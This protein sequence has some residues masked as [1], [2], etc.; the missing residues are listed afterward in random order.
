MP[1]LATSATPRRGGRAHPR[2]GLKQVDPLQVINPH[3]AGIDI[4]AA[5]HY[6]AVPA[7]ADPQSGEN[8]RIFQS[9]TCDLEAIVA[10]LKHCQVTTVAMESTGVYWIP[11]FDLL[12]REGLRPMLVDARRTK[13]L[14]C[15][16]SDVSDCQWI[17]QLHSY[18]LLQPA[19]RP[20]AEIVTL[21]CLVRQRTRLIESAAMCVQHM[22][23]ALNLMNLQLQ[24]VISDITGVTGM[25][26]M[27]AIAKGEM[28][29]PELA[30]ARDRR[31]KASVETIAKALR[32]NYLPEH[33][34]ALRLAL[35]QWDLLQDQIGQ[36]STRINQHLLGIAPGAHPDNLPSISIRKSR[37]TAPD[38]ARD[39]LRALLFTLTGD[40]DLTAI[41]GI[42]DQ[43]AL[44]IISEI[45]RCMSVFP[46]ARHFASWLALCPGCNI[47]G[48]KVLSSKTRCNSNQAAITLR[49]AA[50]SLSRHK[51][52]LGDTFRRL[53]AR[54]GRPKA[55][56][57][58]A[59]K[60]ARII[61]SMLKHKTQY[62]DP[63][64]HAPDLKARERTVRKLNA[65]ARKI[66]FQLMPLPTE[67]QPDKQVSLAPAIEAAV[68]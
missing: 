52:A 63:H 35:E 6:V 4:G 49:L 30:K 27:R 8:V 33:V 65:S 31:C 66:G 50:Q 55:I 43:S 51:G 17:Q 41:P 37:H 46:T 24:H 10:W 14:P 34:F 54:L 9:F 53:C 58:M 39:D 38:A 19:F 2:P 36:C 11:L 47:S 13:N 21:R 5:S 22:Q 1:P 59:H 68:T 20:D 12:A 64:S 40:V 7:G 44:V 67:A 25:L 26:I 61:Y 56:T 29:P 23:Q 48:G 28:D 62:L 3:A 57:A 32:G 18:G 16:K 60:L 45:G 15:R 42:S